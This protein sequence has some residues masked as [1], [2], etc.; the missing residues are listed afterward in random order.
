MAG[1]SGLWCAAQVPV[2]PV[3]VCVFDADTRLCWGLS[4]LLRETFVERLRGGRCGASTGGST[5]RSHC[6]PRLLPHGGGGSRGSQPCG[7][8]RARLTGT[9]STQR[10]GHVTGAALLALQHLRG[11]ALSPPL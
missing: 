2:T 1:G 5:R 6:A 9:L 3:L 11:A 4:L 7:T 8:V 10:L